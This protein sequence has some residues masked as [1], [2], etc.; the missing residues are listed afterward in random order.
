MRFRDRTSGNIL[1]LDEVRFKH[2]NTSFPKQWTGETYDF[3]G[4]DDVIETDA[5]LDTEYKVFVDDGVR[6]VNGKWTQTW[7][8]VDRFTGDELKL[9]EEN[10]LKQK[11]SLIRS[12]RN[13]QLD[14]L[15][16]VLTKHK[17]FL[18]LGHLPFSRD[19]VFSE[20]MYIDLIKYKQLLRDLPATIANVDNF[21]W[22][23]IPM[24]NIESYKSRYV[25]P[26]E[27]PI[28]SINDINKG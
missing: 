15:D 17:E 26:P 1:T 23:V 24:V 28:K 22:P 2:N 13:E 9:Y 19:G 4:V 21:A 10:K 5:P 18:E 16:R 11:W 3:A 20:E 7:K 14:D 12:M 25:P 8:E 6:N 27:V